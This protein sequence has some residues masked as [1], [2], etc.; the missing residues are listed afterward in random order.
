MRSTR[1]A[2]L[3]LS[4]IVAA[5]CSDNGAPTDPIAPSGAALA[6][7]SISVLGCVDQTLQLFPPTTDGSLSVDEEVKLLIAGS[8]TFG[9]GLFVDENRQSALSMWENLKKDKLDSRP[10]QSHIDNEAKFTLTQLGIGGIQDPDGSGLFNAVTGSIR[11]LDLIFRCTGTTPQSLPEPP[12]GFNAEWAIVHQEV[13][14]IIQQFTTSGG[15][16]A[17]AFDGDALPDG[18]LLVIVGEQSSDVQVNTPFPKLSNTVDVAV[19]GGVPTKNLS[20]LV[21]PS[22]LIDHAVNQRAVLAHQF[23]PAPAGAPVGEGVEYLAPAER[24]NLACPGDVASHWSREKGFFRQRLAQLASVAQKAWSFIGPK[25]LYAGHAAIGGI[26]DLGR[27]SPMVA[28]DPFV[29]TAITDVNIPETTYGQAIAFTATLRVSAGPAAWIG[30][31]LTA[32]LPGMPLPLTLAALQITTTLSDGK[33]QTDAIDETGVAHFSFS[34]VN[35]GDHTADLTFPTTLN[36]PANAPL[37]GGSSLLDVPFHVNQAPLDVVPAAATK[38]YGDANPALTGEVQGLQYDDVITATYATTATQESFISTADRTYPITAASVAAGA[39]TLLS[40][41]VYDLGEHS[42]VLTITPRT[43]GGTTANA[44][45]VYGDPNPAF[46]GS[47][48]N[49]VSFSDGLTVSYVNSSVA[50]TPVGPT[51]APAGP[52]LIQSVLGGDAAVNYVDNIPDGTL[53][54][55]VRPLT[56]SIDDQT[57]VQGAE[58][59]DLTGTVNGFVPGDGAVGT[60]TTTALTGSPVG[61]YPITLSVNSANY[62]WQGEDGELTIT[63]AQTEGLGTPTVDGSFTAGE[64]DNARQFQL[65][66]AVPGGDPVAMTL[67]VLNDATN[68]YFAVRFQRSSVN[69]ELTNLLNFEFDHNNN[70]EGPEDGDDYLTV[71][72]SGLL[73]DNFRSGGGLSVTS[74]VTHGSGAFG[75]ANG[76]SLYE[77]SHPLNSGETGDIALAAGQTIGLRMLIQID[78]VSSFFGGPSS[79][80]Q[81]ITIVGAP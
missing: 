2:A 34:E 42:A 76:F 70:S 22:P 8:P 64:W 43:L 21:C 72:T 79:S 60:I 11:V 6:S 44:S 51:G 47:I 35:A 10:L 45:R 80:Y 40:N 28:V 66:A 57:K 67:Y 38:T 77:L 3:V 59:P 30:Q 73:S 58:N 61:T 12:A 13:S 33:T 7:N 23:A 18:T 68:V 36:L 17:V 56:G 14:N 4:A 41:Y 25:P 5:A 46:T 54:I 53:T 65:S 27:L 75:S 52:Y 26:T 31:P 69:P 20:V 19:A 16:V 15:D 63:P 29:E 1:T 55:T 24:G 37:F 62:V 49:G 71:L 32:S 50:T 9:P 78:G 39:G 74:D 81:P 48:T